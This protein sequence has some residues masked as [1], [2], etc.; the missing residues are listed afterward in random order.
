MNDTTMRIYRDVSPS[1]AELVELGDDFVM[2]E[3]RALVDF[4]SWWPRSPRRYGIHTNAIIGSRL[5]L[6]DSDATAL[7]YYWKWL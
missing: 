7:T 5:P 4:Y 2:L 6:L 1:A 3:G